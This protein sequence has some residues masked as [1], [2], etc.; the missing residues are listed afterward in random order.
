MNESIRDEVLALCV[1]AKAASRVL[2]TTETA[3]KDAALLAVADCLEASCDAILAANAEDVAAARER[4]L[5]SAMLDRL[6]LTPARVAAIARA[7]RE[8]AELPDPVGE[9]LETNVRPNG[10]RIEK[11][12]V[13]L[14]VVGVIFESRPNVTVD[15]AVLCLKSGNA[16]VLRGGAEALRTNRAL[17]AAFAE[18][19]A[20][21]GL[22]AACMRLIP[23][24]DRAAVPALCG[25]EGLVDLV[26]PRGG[27]GLVRAVVE[28]ARV[29]VIKHYHGIC[30]VYVDTKAD[31]ATALDILENAKCSRPGVCNAAETLLVDR[32]LAGEFLPMVAERL[33][34]RGVVFRADAPARE[35]LV[36]AERATASDF[37][38]EHLDLIL[39]VACVDGVEG[40]IAHIA[41]H[42]SGHSEA[43]VTRHEA[44]A[45]RFLDAVDAACVYWNAS[46]RFTDGGEF[47]FGAEIGISTDK[48]HARGP[49]GL[50][51]LTTYKYRITGTG[52]TR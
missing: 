30:H 29:P 13:P 7:V 15:T 3:R 37:D 21:A 17:A 27:H 16:T 46:T 50:A 25:A 6:T 2:A 42:G 1:E 33:G 31:L 40:A 18:G 19:V 35:F 38:T 4:G 39:N 12:R 43:I 23:F 49:M 10:L 20:R 9:V 11:R 36:G 14:G 8:V 22:P 51:E 28:S 34:A 24:A 48:L 26:I 52:Q 45:N 47:G 32:K 5:A 41:R 44:T